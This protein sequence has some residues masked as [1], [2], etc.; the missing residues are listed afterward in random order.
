MR[1]KWRGLKDAHG[2]SHAVIAVTS[3]AKK[4]FFHD[5]GHF[6][7]AALHHL[8]DNN[9]I[10]SIHLSLSTPRFE[11]A[12]SVLPFLPHIVNP[13]TLNRTCLPQMNIQYILG[14][15]LTGPAAISSVAR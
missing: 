9:A 15:G 6:K 14:S 1:D 4:Q 3:R 7:A 10:A 5:L 11:A 2:R 12:F 13:G 8:Y